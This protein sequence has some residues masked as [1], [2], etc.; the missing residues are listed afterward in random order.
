MSLWN[1]FEIISGKIARAKMKLFQ[2]NTDEGWNDFI[3]HVTMA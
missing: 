3:S 1:N 2:A